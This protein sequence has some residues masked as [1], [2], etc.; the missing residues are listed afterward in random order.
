MPNFGLYVII[1]DPVLPVEEIAEICVRNEIRYLQV[2]LKDTDDNTIIK[3]G[4]KIKSIIRNSVTKLIIND[5]PDLA[6]ACNA[7][8]VHLGQDDMKIESARKIAPNLIYGLST[9]SIEQAKEALQKSP[10][11]I[12]FGPIYKTPTKKK[13]DPTVGTDLLREVVEFSKVPV[14]AIGGIDLDNFDNVVSTGAK[15]ICLVRWLM[16]AKNLDE[17]I[18]I[19]KQKL[20]EK[21]R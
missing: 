5:R 14:V 11:Y 12:G 17:R 3:L 20:E 1:T 18:K 4:K 16:Q 21:N 6:L 13:P 15:N 7:D 9:H 8:G 10:A 2:R 19:I